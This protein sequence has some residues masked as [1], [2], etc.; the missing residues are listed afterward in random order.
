MIASDPPAAIAC[1][2]ARGADADG[3]TVLAV[4]LEAEDA[5]ERGCA[6]VRCRLDLPIAA[7]DPADL[8]RPHLRLGQTDILPVVR[9]KPMKLADISSDCSLS[10]EKKSACSASDAA[11]LPAR[12]PFES[13]GF[14]APTSAR[15][16]AQAAPQA[17][18]SASGA[19]AS[20]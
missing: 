16:S 10:G 4:R 19:A 20:G 9:Q 14:G 17:R 6:A 5:G 8:T 7:A 18:G 1:L 2:S 12:T 11:G 3:R 13:I 15:A